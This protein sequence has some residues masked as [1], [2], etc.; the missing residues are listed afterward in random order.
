MPDHN[1]CSESSSLFIIIIGI[2]W[3]KSSLIERE[4]SKLETWVLGLFVSIHIPI[5]T[6][7]N[8][9]ILVARNTEMYSIITYCCLNLFFFEF[10][11]LSSS[12]HFKEVNGEQLSLLPIKEIWLLHDYCTLQNTFFRNANLWRETWP[13]KAALSWEEFFWLFY[14]VWA[15]RLVSWFSCQELQQFSWI[16][17]HDLEKSCKILRT[18]PRIIAKILAWNVKNPIFFL[19]RKPRLG[20]RPTFKCADQFFLTLEV[21][22]K[23][24]RFSTK[25]NMRT[26][27]LVSY[28]HILFVI[29]W[30][31]KSYYFDH[32]FI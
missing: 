8:G 26:R 32:F 28:S 25:T 29:L 6:E 22:F 24:C 7:S 1:T 5:R 30:K 27:S 11:L 21:T 12:A 2:P 23:M 19:A 14:N 17:S 3:W 4:I 20:K 16:S 18:V 10:T 13:T 15:Q 9:Y 31:Q